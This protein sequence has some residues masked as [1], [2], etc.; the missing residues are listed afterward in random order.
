MPAILSRLLMEI[1]M[2]KKTLLTGACICAFTTLSNAYAH[3]EA[4]LERPDDHA[5]IGV[6]RDHVHGQGEWMLSY[7]F[8]YMHM[9]GNRDGTSSVSTQDVLNNYMVAPTEMPMRMHMFGAMYG[10]TDQ[11]TVSVMGGFADKEMDHVRRNGTTFVMDNDGITDTKVNALYEFYNDGE[12][13]LQANAGVSLPTGS[14]NE[15]MANGMVMAYPMQLGS[16]TYDFLPGISYSGR[17]DDWSWG[18][19]A[20]ATLRLGQNDRGYSLGNRYQ[21]TAWGARKLNEMFSI[22]ARLD[23]Q[24][25]EDVDGTDRELTG[26]MFMAPTMDADLQDGERIE[27]LVG[28]N[29]IVPSGDLKGNRLAAEFGMPVYERL[30]GPRLETDYRFM[31]GWQYA[32]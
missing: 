31:L 5:P 13:R 26:P 28:V 32:F 24:A 22:S 11:L 29:F 23:G 3:E 1:R 12:H 19:Q 16:G 2:L 7:R 21:L 30:D 9:D 10:I 8:G 25:R 17:S 6:M 18:G 4:L 15:R 27:A 20:N 14:I